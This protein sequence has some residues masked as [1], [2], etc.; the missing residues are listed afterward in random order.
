MAK[1]CFLGFVTMEAIEGTLPGKMFQDVVKSF[2]TPEQLEEF[3]RTGDPSGLPKVP[4]Y[5]PL[6]I[7]LSEGES[8][9]LQN[10]LEEKNKTR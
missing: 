1:L 6:L 7:S 9:R 3:A 2:Y 8:S 4:G 5:G 10:Q